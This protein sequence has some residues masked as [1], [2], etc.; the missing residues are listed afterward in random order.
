MPVVSSRNATTRRY[1]VDH[2]ERPI[3]LEFEKLRLQRHQPETDEL[4]GLPEHR[5][6]PR[7]VPERVLLAGRIVIVQHGPRNADQLVFR[8]HGFDRALRSLATGI[9]E[10]RDPEFQGQLSRFAGLETVI[11]RLRWHMADS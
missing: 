11:D 8:Q 6:L 1:D 2:L 10:R 3:G 5:V 4:I 9:V 7:E